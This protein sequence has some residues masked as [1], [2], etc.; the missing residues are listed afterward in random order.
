MSYQ[1]HQ[2]NIPERLVTFEGKEYRWL[3]GTNY[4]SI[5]MH[6]LFQEKLQEG[7]RKFSQNW[8]SSRLNNYQMDVWQSLEEVFAKRYQVEAASLCSSGLLA[9]QTVM[10]YLMQK[11]PDA[12]I[13]LAPKTHPALWRHPHKPQEES[14]LDWKSD[15]KILGMD[16]IGAPWVEEFLTGF[17]QELRE[18]QVLVVDES[19]RLGIVSTAINTPAHSI[20]TSSLSKAYGIPAGIILGKKADIEAIKKDPFWVGGSPPNPAYMYACLHAQEAYEE[21]MKHS[22]NL[23]KLFTEQ[24]Q[25]VQFVKDYPAFSAQ[26]AQLFEHLKNHGFLCNQFA[27]PDVTAKPICKAILPASLG[28]KDIEDL[29]AALEKYEI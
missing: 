28:L 11:Y 17:E 23:A 22:Q 18:E 13:S 12:E 14:F 3:G 27:Y 7:I 5:G 2:P 29:L 4:L 19:H 16:G 26:D 20:Q 15:A 8:G 1:I 9:G 25:H 21:R 24:A 6:P 10:Q